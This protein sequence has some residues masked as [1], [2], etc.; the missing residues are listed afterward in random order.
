MVASL[1]YIICVYLRVEEQEEAL[2]KNMRLCAC[3]C[4]RSR[5][6]CIQIKNGEYP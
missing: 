2:E 6:Y 4:L 5:E 3:A 1:F